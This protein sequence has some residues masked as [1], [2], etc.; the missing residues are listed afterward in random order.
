MR[1]IHLPPA[2]RRAA[3]ARLHSADDGCLI[4]TTFAARAAADGASAGA[5]PSCLPSSA[6]LDASLPPPAPASAGA[7]IAAQPAAA[8]PPPSTKMASRA[9]AMASSVASSGLRP[10][11]VCAA[12]APPPL[13]AAARFA[14]VRP[15]AVRAG[16]VL[17]CRA[18]SRMQEAEAPLTVEPGDG[19]CSLG[20]QLPVCPGARPRVAACGELR[21]REVVVRALG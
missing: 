4:G 20:H 10:D 16:A 8:A 15:A 5:R 19:M 1:V 2:V 17:P 6:H 11:D 14:F 7:P 21:P 9:V 12:A 3:G 13:P 18:R